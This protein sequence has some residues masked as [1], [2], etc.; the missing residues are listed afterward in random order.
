VSQYRACLEHQP[1]VFVTDN[2]KLQCM[3][4]SC[5]S[6]QCLSCVTCMAAVELVALCMK[7]NLTRF[8]SITYYA[9]TSSCV[10]AGMSISDTN[11]C[12]HYKYMQWLLSTVVYSAVKRQIC[13][14]TE[15]RA[16]SATRLICTPQHFSAAEMSN[17]HCSLKRSSA[18]N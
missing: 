12:I 5:I 2:G 11:R 14:L 8:A 16:A 6:C 7:A 13:A 17:A 10:T 3:M 15:R 1:S 4:L 9:A 18:D